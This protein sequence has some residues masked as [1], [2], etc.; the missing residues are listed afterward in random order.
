MLQATVEKWAES[1]I[2]GYNDY[3]NGPSCERGFIFL[4]FFIIFFFEFLVTMTTETAHRVEEALVFIFFRILGY[5]DYRNGPS[6]ERGFRF[7]FFIYF[8][9]I[10]YFFFAGIGHDSS[11]W[12]N[13]E[14][15]Q[16]DGGK[17]NYSHMPPN[18]FKTNGT[19]RVWR[20]R[21]WR[22]HRLLRPTLKK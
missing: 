17:Q 4:N 8:F 1:R 2:L 13:A 5:N 6:C 10:F 18:S 14:G 21:I 19:S 22:P 11:E 16:R 3:R 12:G 15:V 20:L 9:F 7:F